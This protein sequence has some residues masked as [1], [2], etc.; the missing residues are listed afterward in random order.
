MRNLPFVPGGK[1]GGGTQGRESK[2]KNTK[3]K[4][5]GH[6]GG[7]DSD[8]DEVTTTSG[9]GKN[10]EVELEFLSPEEIEKKLLKNERLEGCP[11][12]LVSEVANTLYR[13]AEYFSSKFLAWRKG[14]IL[15]S[16]VH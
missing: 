8:D 1:S 2:N 13:W 5:K 4:Y 9:G 12:E 7:G 15:T 3:K 6:G 14:V 11:E 10:K 16:L